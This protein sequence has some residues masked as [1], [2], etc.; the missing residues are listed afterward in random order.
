MIKTGRKSG[1]WLSVQ[2][3]QQPLIGQ[4]AA[5]FRLSFLQ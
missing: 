4:H 1:W 5:N 2:E 3:G